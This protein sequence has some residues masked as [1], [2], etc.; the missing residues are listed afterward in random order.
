MVLRKS[1]YFVIISIVFIFM[2]LNY[3]LAQDETKT[4]LDIE[5]GN[6][7]MSEEIK[8]Y[9]LEN[10]VFY[11]VSEDAE[12]SEFDLENSVVTVEGFDIAKLGQQKISV[13]V[14]VESLNVGSEIKS[15]MILQEDILINLVD[16]TAPVLELKRESLTLKNGASFDATDYISS[17][18]DY[19]YMFDKQVKTESNVDT[20][21]AGVYYVT[22]KSIDPSMNEAVKTLTVNVEEKYVAKTVYNDSN[23][24]EAML[25]EMNAYRASHGLSAFTLAGDSALSAASVRASEAVDYTSHTRPSG[26]SYKTALDDFGVD[27]NIAYEILTYSGST[28]SDKIEWWSNSA[29]HNKI[30]L[31]DGDYKVAYGYDGKMWAALI[32][33]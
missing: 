26:Q 2:S 13:I 27:Y 10:S 33:N 7:S 28:I 15:H 30:M 1:I 9:V 8:Q 16:T 24:I 31:L 19:D 12:V 17:V 20:T 22:Y 32:Y 29:G 4:V 21:V 25:N 6:A 3:V 5:L 23:T 14:E 18:S 11:K